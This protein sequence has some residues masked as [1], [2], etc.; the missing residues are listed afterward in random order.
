[1]NVLDLHKCQIF[2][3]VA[4][5][6]SFTRA[7]Q[8]LN[9]TQPTVSQQVASLEATLNVELLE[10]STRHLR[11]TEAGEVLYRYT[12]QLITLSS[13]ALDAVQTAAGLSV[14][15]L[16]L[17]VGHTL[18]TYLL[19]GTLRRYRSQYPDDQVR[20]SVGNTGELLE[21]LASGAID[22]ALVGSP[23]E[24][25]EVIT[26][27]FMRD[28]LLVIVSADDSW[29]ERESATLDD[30]RERLLLTREPG[31]ALYRT[32]AQLMGESYLSS[33]GVMLLG[34]TEAIKRSVELGLGV[35]LIQGI[36]IEREVHSG[37]LKALS[38]VEADDSRTYLIAT[39][40][41]ANLNAAAERF[42]TVLR[43]TTLSAE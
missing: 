6:E 18:A 16:K 24:H 8:A 30:L 1:M 11:L 15:T 14:Q 21:L 2:F 41:R 28:R 26:E 7:A 37:T 10:R 19:P 20:L 22:V 36:A 29:A 33:E 32:I 34:E 12:G 17:G 35:A 23:A 38:L 25:A 40:K 39:R 42:I 5:L 3:T 4:R 9:M 43:E 31:S 13:E 27:P